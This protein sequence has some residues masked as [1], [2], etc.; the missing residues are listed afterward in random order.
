MDTIAM[1]GSPA[2]RGAVASV[3]DDGRACLAGASAVSAVSAAIAVRVTMLGGPQRRIAALDGAVANRFIM[4][5]PGRNASPCLRRSNLRFTIQFAPGDCRP[6]ESALLYDSPR[7][8]KDAAILTITRF[9]LKA[10]HQGRPNTER[11]QAYQII[12]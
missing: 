12:R 3:G 8:W 1:I 11:A 9:R 7:Q 10:L 2:R 5:C 6:S 4:P